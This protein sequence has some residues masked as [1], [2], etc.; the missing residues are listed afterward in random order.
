ML[1]SFSEKNRVRLVY[2]RQ[3]GA[4][5]KKSRVFEVAVYFFF[6]RRYYFIYLKMNIYV[7]SIDIY[8]FFEI[9]IDKNTPYHCYNMNFMKIIAVLIIE[10][11]SN[12]HV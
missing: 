8:F 12:N 5:L 3:M 10:T 4:S 1:L 7:G 11:V 6:K 2:V 9:Y